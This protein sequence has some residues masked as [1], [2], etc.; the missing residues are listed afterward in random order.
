VK[1][2][3][4]TYN[5][6]ALIFRSALF[7]IWLIFL[8]LVLAL[9]ALLTAIISPRL[10]MRVAVLWSQLILFGLKHLCGLHYRIHGKENLPDHACIVMSKHQSTF[11]CFALT[12][13]LKYQVFVAKRS[14]TLIPIF[15]WV[16]YLQRFILINRKSGGTAISQMIEQSK[17]RLSES[18]HIVIFPEGTRMPIAAAPNYRV[19]GAVVASKIGADVLPVAHNAGEFWPRMGFIKWPGQINMYVGPIISGK[20]KTPDEILTETQT[21]IEAKMQEITVPHRFPYKK[22]NTPTPTTH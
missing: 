13:M 9:P 4:K 5:R 12:V 2:S 10:S 16:I 14:L 18:T 22:T 3:E 6:P 1:T 11:E 19:G 15:G 20:G 7:W 21:W 17:L 8:T